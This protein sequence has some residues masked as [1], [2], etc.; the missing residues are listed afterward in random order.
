[1]LGTVVLIL[2]IITL[3][4][5]SFTLVT[6]IVTPLTAL[7]TYYFVVTSMFSVGVAPTVNFPANHSFPSQSSVRAF[8]RSSSSSPL[9]TISIYF[10]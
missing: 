9:P 6:G 7:S 4:V 3:P 8:E 2:L 10:P 5:S 1:L